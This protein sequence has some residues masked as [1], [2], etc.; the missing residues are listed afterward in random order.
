M[1]KMRFLRPQKSLYQNGEN[2]YVWVLPATHKQEWIV[3]SQMSNTKSEKKL[4]TT[5][6]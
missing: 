3:C 6:K 2:L 4:T 5:T 1:S